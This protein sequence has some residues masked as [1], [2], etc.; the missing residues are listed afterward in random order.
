MALRKMTVNTVCCYA[1]CRSVKCRYVERR[2]AASLLRAGVAVAAGAAMS[3]L[4]HTDKL[5]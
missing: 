5:T 3:T 2:S 4:K 1:E